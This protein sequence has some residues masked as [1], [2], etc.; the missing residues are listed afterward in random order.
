MVYHESFDPE[1]LI[2]E[3]EYFRYLATGEWFDR[4]QINEKGNRNETER[5]LNEYK[6]RA[7]PGQFGLH[8]DARQVLQHPN[9]QERIYAEQPSG[10]NGA[11]Q[12]SKE[13]ISI[14]RRGRPKNVNKNH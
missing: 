6:E 4:P 13:K 11:N 5:L 7:E 2:E 12:S 9:D 3:E 10:N 8:E 14:K 1:Y